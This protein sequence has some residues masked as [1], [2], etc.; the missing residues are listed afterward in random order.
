M[1]DEKS[2][3]LMPV[4][5]NR[6]LEKVITDLAQA[7]AISDKVAKTYKELQETLKRFMVEN[8]FKKID[9]DDCP[10]AVTYKEPSTRETFDTKRFKKDYPDLYDEYTNITDTSD[11]L[12]I[13]LKEV[14]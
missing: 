8:N 13:K 2:L 14:E 3:M 5:D 7:K 11:S 12:L 9:F 1:A 6:T 10:V 4:D